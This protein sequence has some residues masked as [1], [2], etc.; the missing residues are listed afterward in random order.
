MLEAWQ[1]VTYGVVGFIMAILS[2]IAGAGGGFIMTPLLILLGLTPAQAVSTGKFNGLAV[3]IGSLS[4]L[5]G[6]EGKVSRR[7]IAAIMALAFA[8]G[9][10]APFAIKSFESRSYRIALGIILLLM[11]PVMLSRKIG[12]EPR[13]PTAA[14]R[15][16][17]G[18]R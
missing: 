18:T 8:V 17:T 3:T 7:R 2:G 5:R 11:I 15:S 9:L 13:K 1:L 16:L 4:G 6:Y 10:A 12:V 14:A